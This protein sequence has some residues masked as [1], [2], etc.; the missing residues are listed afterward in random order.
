MSSLQA[1]TL[2]SARRKSSP[3]Q[4]RTVWS[5]T[6]SAVEKNSSNDSELGTVGKISWHS[7]EQTS[8][9]RVPI[10]S[11]GIRAPI[12]GKTWVPT[13]LSPGYSYGYG[14]EHKS[15]MEY[16]RSVSNV[17]RQTARRVYSHVPRWC[18]IKGP[19]VGNTIGQ[20][21]MSV[22]LSRR[23]WHDSCLLLFNDC[24]H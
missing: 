5:P 10:P 16:F 17:Q 11:Y 12:N 23:D 18:L 3:V 4:S 14:G 2:Q 24:W 21:G 6:T 7:T 22:L 15:A 9:F 13:C 20:N 8:T 1:V 19:R